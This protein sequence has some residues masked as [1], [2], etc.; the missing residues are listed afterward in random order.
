[1]P[2]SY[3]ET[4]IVKFF[5]KKIDGFAYQKLV[6]GEVYNKSK[7]AKVFSGCVFVWSSSEASVLGILRL[8]GYL[9]KST[10]GLKLKTWLVGFEY[11]EDVQVPRSILGAFFNKV[12]TKNV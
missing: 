7:Q 11:C 6:C 8:H 12:E 2:G 4:N 5:E 10:P 9:F 1:M 3:T